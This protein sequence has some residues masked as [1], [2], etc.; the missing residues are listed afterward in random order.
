MLDSHTNS[1]SNGQEPV[2]YSDPYLYSKD[3][4]NSSVASKY[5]QAEAP[6][7]DNESNCSSTSTICLIQPKIM[8]PKKHHITPNILLPVLSPTPLL[9]MSQPTSANPDTVLVQRRTSQDLDD[10]NQDPSSSKKRKL[11]PHEHQQLVKD[12]I[13]RNRAAAQESRDKKKRQMERLEEINDKLAR[14]NQLLNSRMV[15]LESQNALLQ[16]QMTLIL[17]GLTAS[18][19][20]NLQNLP[21]QQD[22][23]QDIVSDITSYSS[24]LSPFALPP[25]ENTNNGYNNNSHS[26]NVSDDS[27]LKDLEASSSSFTK[28]QNEDNHV[29]CRNADPAADSAL[30][31]YLDLGDNDQQTLELP[32]SPDISCLQPQKYFN[33]PSKQHQIDL[34]FLD[35]LFDL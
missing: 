7:S 20:L 28:S 17:T 18:S 26:E 35:E 11:S 4:E 13:L 32:Y 19:T 2:D 25:P 23:H 5:I 30:E 22:T 12:R 27:F 16:T 15:L 6:S 9:P 8:L 21:S 1:Q 34:S 14:E 31:L 29:P 24:L 33:P 3:T 10:S